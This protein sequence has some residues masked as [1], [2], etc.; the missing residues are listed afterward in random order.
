MFGCVLHVNEAGCVI[1][2]L[3]LSGFLCS[4]LLFLGLC[5]CFYHLWFMH[6]SISVD[7]T[8]MSLW[9]LRESRFLTVFVCSSG[10]L[11]HWY[12]CG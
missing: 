10:C 12:G 9:F 2:I 7:V 11:Q 3:W 8:H 1:Q 6:S 5:I 4:N